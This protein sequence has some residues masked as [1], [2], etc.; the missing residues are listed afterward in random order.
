MIFDLIIIALVLGA[1]FIGYRYGTSKELY[2]LAKVFVGMSVAGTYAESLGWGLTRT[3]L[4]LAND[5]AVLILTG[6]LLLF[7]FYWIIMYFLE[8]LFMMLEMQKSVANCYLGMTANGI[9]AILLLSFISFMSTQLTF[10]KKGYKS[11]LVEKSFIYIHMDRLCR[12]F[13]TAD[14]VKDVTKNSIEE[15]V[16]KLK[17]GALIPQG[18]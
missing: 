14:F 1:V 7:G 16:Q 8:H 15:S 13:I 17:T 18:K 9:Q 2:H 11:Y 10:V 12:N 5:K 6:Y 4:L 3:G